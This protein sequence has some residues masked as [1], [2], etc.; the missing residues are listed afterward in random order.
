VLADLSD[1][2]GLA[3]LARQ[4][5]E[6]VEVL[7]S[8]TCPQVGVGGAT[9]ASV[10][11]DDVDLELL[12]QRV[13]S[14]G[15]IDQSDGDGDDSVPLEPGVRSGVVEEVVELSDELGA[16]VGVGEGQLVSK[17]P[18]EE[19]GVVS[20]IVHER[21]DVGLHDS[22]REVGQLVLLGKE[23]EDDLEVVRA[24]GVHEWD[25]VRSVALGGVASVAVDQVFGDGVGV[26]ESDHVSTGS[27]DDGK[28]TIPEGLEP[29]S[30]VASSVWVYAAIEEV[31]IETG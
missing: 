25:V 20:D 14:E 2:N 1:K 7:G 4:A 31:L 10:G 29:A 15:Q 27:G 26:I 24:A 13:V 28:V 12:R 17:L 5:V 6:T 11:G 23:G 3:G 22:S 9:V 18:H 8:I 21:S 16:H 30:L 19:G